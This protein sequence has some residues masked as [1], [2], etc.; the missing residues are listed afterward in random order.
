MIQTEHN[1]NPARKRRAVSSE[2]P[3]PKL[4]ISVL[5]YKI[6]LRNKLITIKSNRNNSL[7]QVR[8]L[9]NE[10]VYMSCCC[11]SYDVNEI[12]LKSLIVG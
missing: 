7:G 8:M 11:K 3:L 12:Q 2:I 6:H 1:I 4:C 10:V 9:N 5:F